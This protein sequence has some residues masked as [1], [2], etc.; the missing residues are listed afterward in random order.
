MI[1]GLRKQQ[2]KRLLTIL[3]WMGCALLAALALYGLNQYGLEPLREQIKSLGVFAPLG[4]ALLRGISIIL[5]ILPS[6]AYL[7]L[8]GT[9]LG[10][11]TGVATVVIADLLFCQAAFFIARSYG[12]KPVKKLIGEQAM[13]RVESFNKNQLEDNLFM[14][15]GLL[16][17][18][19]FDFVSY[20]IGLSGTPWRRFAPALILS[21]VIS[22]PP[23]VALGAGILEGGKVILGFAILGIF[24]LAITRLLTQR[25][26]KSAI[27][28]CNP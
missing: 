11:K 26:Q 16:M 10:F 5:P 7:L 20:A 13:E 3:K 27:D 14:M 19:L 25:S 23:L 22:D 17:T 8:A 15:T 9:L 4:I 6:T 21:V 24:G 12:R 2:T 1:L 28:E 18:G